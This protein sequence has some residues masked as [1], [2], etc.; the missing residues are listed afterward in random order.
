[1]SEDTKKLAVT[2]KPT[3]SLEE[4]KAQL[5]ALQGELKKKDTRINRL[6]TDSGK[7]LLAFEARLHEMESRR[8]DLAEEMAEYPEEYVEKERAH[9]SYNGSRLTQMVF[10]PQASGWTKAMCNKYDEYVKLG[11]EINK[12]MEQLV[13]VTLIDDPDV[14]D[15]QLNV[16]VN[17]NL[18]GLYYSGE[19]L[20]SVSEDADDPLDRTQKRVQ[21]I[22]YKH[23]V[24]IMQSYK[25]KFK[26][27]KNKLGHEVN[28]PYKVRP[29][30]EAQLPT[31][32]MIQKHKQLTRKSR[33][34]RN[35]EM[36]S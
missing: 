25:V 8:T 5:E 36:A 7:T 17:G 9:K 2:E 21:L 10:C 28:V 26:I 32:E 1:M 34:T 4:M 12:A 22:P 11:K 14:T 24:A 30:I 18:I 23:Y 3:Q 20:F 16:G 31:P 15:I 29:V 19:N 13:A 35:M 27:R 6:E 33:M